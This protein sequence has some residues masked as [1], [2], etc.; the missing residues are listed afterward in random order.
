MENMVKAA[1]VPDAQ[2]LSAYSGKRVFITGDTGF[3][4]SWLS[5]W[6]SE[7]G[8][9]V[10]GY[11]LPPGYPRS[12]FEL[13]GLDRTIRHIDGDIRDAASLAK[14]LRAARPEFVFHLAAQSLVRRSYADPLETFSTNVLGSAHLLDAVRNAPS[15]RALIYV[16]SDKCYLNKEWEWSY[17]ET[18]ELGGH[19]P[20][21][22]S[23][24][25]AEKV[26]QGY[27][28]S[29]LKHR[30]ELGAATVR[31]GNVIGG[32]DWA[33]DRLIP[34]CIRALQNGKPIVLRNPDA[35]RPWQF[36]LE[37]VGGYLAHALKLAQA[38]Q[39]YAGSWNY[40]PEAGSLRTVAEVVG[41]IIELWGAG[42]IERET[43]NDARH[44][45]MLLQ[46]SIDKVRGQLGWRPVYDAAKSIDQTVRWYRT[47]DR[48][49]ASAADLS[50]AQIREYM[51]AA[52]DAAKAAH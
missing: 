41:R 38:P 2:T 13:L 7:L 4:G 32:G 20:Y 15:V 22:A 42:K 49:N 14:H 27:Y 40:G 52:A 51:A 44:E 9:E 21:S 6:L 18:D 1:A 16:T 11:A 37:P 33:E 26:F 30:P 23:K 45:A 10:T 29:F 48:G 43:A 24:A 12:H 17:R 50:R 3:K 28:H 35:T 5:L 25:A 34:D 19:D 46:L 39:R 31:A 47:M 36:V 8:A